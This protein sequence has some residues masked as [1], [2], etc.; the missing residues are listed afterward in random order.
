VTG[1]LL[2]SAELA[3][4]QVRDVRV[5]DGVVTEVGALARRP[6]EPEWDCRGAAL[7][8][9]LCDHHLHLHALAAADSSVP[10]GPPAATDPAALA[11]ALAGAPADRNGW[12]RG[13]GYVES[14][15]GELDAAALDRLHPGRPVR[16]QHRSGALWMLN[17]AA[18]DRLGL[19]GGEHPGIERHRD[20]APTGRLWRA[21]D[22]LRSRL[23]ARRPPDLAGVGRRLAVLGITAVTDAT[24]DL[25]PEAVDA[26]T[27]AN[28]S[29]ALPQRV[30]LLGAPPE[31][32][33]AGPCKIVLADSCL[34]YLDALTERIRATHLTGR[35]VAAHCVTQEALVLLLAALDDAA[36]VAG[37]RIE[38]AALVPE[39]LLP[40]LAAS[41][42]RV[43][44]QPGFLADRG[45]DY[46]SG[47]PTEQHADLYRCRSLLAAGVPLALSSDAPYGPL[48]P[49]AVMA[50]AVHRS[51][52]SGVVAGPEERLTPAQA[53]HGYLSAPEQPGGP[54]RRVTVGAAADLVLLRAPLA[55]VL[56]APTADA[57]RATLIAGQVTDG[58]HRAR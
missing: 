58:N 8:P 21:D 56:R 45:D 26:I 47:L 38:H 36:I 10:C 18:L 7:L 16:I 17:R 40:R 35:P 2:R 41:G 27:E 53:L 12:V 11:S 13:I 9:G 49:W 22:W 31:H 46:L 42:L 50:A 23:P 5:T 6:G 14:V 48:D 29:G 15:A 52:R 4:R 25:A 51:T 39:E 37:D 32:P 34:P 30:Q 54:A 19:T 24:P 44:T 43:V 3:G 55:E 28:R 33:G 57:V 20:G 1:L